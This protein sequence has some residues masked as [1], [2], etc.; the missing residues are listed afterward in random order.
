M[1]A[2]LV[3]VTNWIVYLLLPVPALCQVPL[4]DTRGV[5]YIPSGVGA[6][7]VYQGCE[8]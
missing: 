8:I 7:Q 1:A 5:Y 2:N 3:M 6:A 4:C